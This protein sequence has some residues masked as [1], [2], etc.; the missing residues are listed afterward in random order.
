MTLVKDLILSGVAITGAIVA[1]KGLSTWK[2]QLKGQSEYELSRRILVALFKYRDA[3]NGVR[4]PVMW[5]FEIPNPPEE[6]SKD[7]SREHIR[8]YG[9]SKA[10]QARWD[11][12]QA[13]RTN[14]YADLLEGEAI[15]GGELKKLFKVLFN[16]EH[17]LLTSV[18]RYI[19]LINPD[20]EEASKE[21]IRNIEKKRRD[22][23][24][25]D[26]SEEGDEYR[27]DFQLGVEEIE[28]YLKPKLTY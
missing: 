6:E 15:W 8:F 13:E 4:H 11:K 1:I 23:M 9:T 24:Y 22:I 21:A 7:M 2:R 25:D 28:K 14:L 18:R 5:D 10:Y 3:I 19:D 16:L 20:K 17:E 26:L 12:V 27:K